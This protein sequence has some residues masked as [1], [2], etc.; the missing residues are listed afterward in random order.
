MKYSAVVNL[1]RR[2]IFSINICI[3]DTKPL[4]KLVIE[5]S[6]YASWQPRQRSSFLRYFTVIDADILVTD[7]RFI[8]QLS[9]P[10]LEYLF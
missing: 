2:V 8:A 6:M 7:I 4:L 3:I 10:V 5:T 1:G 9:S